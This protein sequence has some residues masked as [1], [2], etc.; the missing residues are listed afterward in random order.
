MDYLRAALISFALAIAVL[1]LAV[2]EVE[3]GTKV[4]L[5]LLMLFLLTALPAAII[6]PGQSLQTWLVG[7]L[8]TPA[9]LF[10]LDAFFLRLGVYNYYIYMEDAWHPAVTQPILHKAAGLAL[11]GNLMFW[12][13]YALPFGSR[14]GLRLKQH[15]ERWGQGPFVFSEIR[16]W[17]LFLIGLAARFYLLRSG[18]GGFFSYD[19][20]AQTEALGYIQLIVLAESLTVLALL[21]YFARVMQRG[22][23]GRR[24]AFVFMLGVE[25]LTVFFM[26]F[27]GQVVYRLIY[28][29]VAYIYVRR[30]LPL[31]I[32]AIAL[33][34]LI[35]VMPVNL[36]MRSQYL[37]GQGNIERSQVGSIWRD[38]V[39]AL[40]QVA[41][42]QSEYTFKS[43]LER[44]AR[45]S[46]QLE[47]LA[48]AIGYVDR[49]GQTLKGID[50]LSFFY[51]FIPRAI[52][53]T[54]PTLGLG[55][56]ATNVVYGKPGSY[57]SALTVAGDFYVN[58]GFWAI[59]VGFIFYGFLLST[60]TVGVVQI[61]PS[62]RLIGIVAFLIVALGIPSSDL[63]SYLAKVMRIVVVYVVA[64][65]FVLFPRP[66]HCAES[67]RAR[68]NLVYD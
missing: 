56:W 29:A 60:V 59:P 44:V 25:L 67:V 39:D 24:L 63:G 6:L 45:H 38:A 62:P 1:L 42:G 51:S 21:S 37:Y 34:A 33:L 14:L 35:V 57:S 68:G 64:S 4:V 30:R 53:P 47:P 16:I 2:F 5:Y 12:I 50:F 43:S 15:V 58:L 54:K 18:L 19:A 26:G 27:K 22:R 65:T 40:G 11:L 13:G 20:Q 8:L 32:M 3:Q 49:S 52:W 61:K 17:L 66:Q 28:L 41:E 9:L 31:S 7:F 23:T 48:M 10:S 36:L 46:A 55:V